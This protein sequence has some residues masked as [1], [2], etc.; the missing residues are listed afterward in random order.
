MAIDK[1]SAQLIAD[2]IAKSTKTSA[3]P[4]VSLPTGP[5]NVFKDSIEKAK[6]GLDTLSNA[7]KKLEDEINLGIGTFR[8]L[9]KTGISFGNDI[10]GMSVAAKGTRMDLG[11][12]ADTVKNNSVFLAGFGGSINEGAREFARVSKVMYDEYGVTTDR[13]R[14]MGLTNKDLNDVLALQAG[15]IG[16]SMRQSKQRDQIAIESATAL[17]TEMDLM[18]KMTGKSRNEQMESAKKLQ[19][20]AAF[21]AKLE[22][23]TRNMNETQAAEYRTKIMAEFTKA[24][25]IGLG[26]GFKETFTFGQVLTKQAANEQVMAGKAGIEITKA[27]TAAAAGN[28][29][30]ASRRNATAMEAAAAN[31]KNAMFQNMVIVG[32]FTGGVGE[33][34]QKQFMANK[35]LA[36]NIEL[37]KKDPENKGKTDAE[38]LAMARQKAKEEQDASSGSTKAMIQV[39]QRM[40][41]VSS[42][43]AN[44]LVGPINKDVSPAL[45][46][47]ADTVLSTRSA[48]I[49]GDREKNNIARTEGELRAGREQFERGEQPRGSA[50][51][52]GG[53]GV[54]KLSKGFNK[55]AEK[56]ID[57]AVT[58]AEKQSPRTPPAPPAPR[59]T[60]TYGAGKMFEDVGA[61]LEITKPGEVVLTGEQQ[62]NL[63]KGMMDKGASTAFN[64]LSKNLDFSKLSA[65]M[66]KLEMPK[67]EMPKL[68]LNKISR[69][70]S[71]TVSGGGA[72]TI[73]IPKT[74][75]AEMTRPF[76]KS[77]DEFGSNFDDV[78]AKMSNDLKDAIPLD[79]L[80]QTAAA[81]EFA[82]KRRQELEEMYLDGV[83]R[84]SAEWNEIDAE[85]DQ[86]DSQIEKLT[87]KQLDAMSN[88][89]DGWDESSDIMDRVAADI[90]DTIPVDEFGDLDK[91]IAAQKAMDQAAT[92]ASP[93]AALDRGITADS[94]TLGPN[95]LPIA[96][97][98]SVAAA[99]PE[100]K[101]EKSE[102]EQ[103]EENRAKM[104]AE[105]ARQ[106]MTLS[107][108]KEQ[109]A[110]KGKSEKS[111][112]LDDLHK[113][114]LTLNMQMG[115]LIAVNEDGH[116][117]SAKAAKSTNT[118]LYAR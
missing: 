30:E 107:E 52:V 112:T 87:N 55:D 35:A 17:A 101:S 27:A 12:F 77:F 51:A 40:K 117:A 42:V 3:T 10:I 33:A 76:E 48:L 98:K 64:N 86:L 29:E 105:A 71:T 31:N 110:T 74:N 45:T 28:F 11:E 78:V 79:T 49:P 36:D 19:A 62:M 75:M 69:D 81:L 115:Q 9:S 25:A 2:A 97:P 82:T 39:E 23:Q 89:A 58:A 96:K 8:D 109:A 46:K 84:T 88:Y 90:A 47:L 61:I 43:I 114:L 65:G 92:A 37:L 102:A 72:S 50:V 67:F 26:Q 95:G 32:A 14:N 56:T 116:K 63:A 68:D 13:L 93:S 91:A 85:A 22:Q 44:G 94:F 21:Q 24:E 7:Y 80:D 5:V 53:F 100:K 16:N 1:A 41:D 4:S 83:A 103:A 15:M 108:S 6:G 18:A 34:A 70:I 54:A 60:G 113:S 57:A 118:N 66:P 38:L 73:N 59:S 20:D 106:G 111:A 104:K 99:V